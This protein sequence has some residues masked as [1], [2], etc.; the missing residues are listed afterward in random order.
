MVI[1]DISGYIDTYGEFVVLPEFEQA[2]SFYSLNGRLVALAKEG[3]MP[4]PLEEDDEEVG[5]M[6]DENKRKRKCTK[7]KENFMKKKK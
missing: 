5:F 2:G 1:G 7:R 4:P 6:D 3:D